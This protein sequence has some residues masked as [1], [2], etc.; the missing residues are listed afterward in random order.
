MQE[1]SV[2]NKLFAYRHPYSYKSLRK[3]HL[4][5]DDDQGK[6]FPRVAEVEDVNDAKE[7]LKDDG[8]GGRDEV[9]RLSAKVVD[10]LCNQKGGNQPET[11]KFLSQV[12]A[13]FW[14]DWKIKLPNKCHDDCR[15]VSV[16]VDSLPVHQTARILPSGVHDKG[17]DHL[18]T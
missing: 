9:H 12:S 4:A 16:L 10:V 15:P 2:D 6:D 3:N 7:G 11:I 5:A 13:L 17:H 14:T 1:S 18:H 8:G